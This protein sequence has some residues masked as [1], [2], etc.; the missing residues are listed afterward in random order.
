MLSLI[1]SL[2]SPL[3]FSPCF[4]VFLTIYP[5]SCHSSI[6]ISC[7][8]VPP[9]PS[10]PFLCFSFCS[11]LPIFLSTDC[12]QMIFGTNILFFC[13]FVSYNKNSMF[14]PKKSVPGRMQMFLKRQE[15]HHGTLLLPTERNWNKIYENH[16]EE[17]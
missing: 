1:L 7:S 15:D 12:G 6:S 11:Y 5:S 14:P 3:L 16:L 13:N 9:Q 17:F 4:P 2:I 8:C 10:S